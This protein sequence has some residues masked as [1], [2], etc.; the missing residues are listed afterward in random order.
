[1]KCFG[2]SALHFGCESN[3]CAKLEVGKENCV[4]TF[5]K[6][7]YCKNWETCSSDC[8]KKETITHLQPHCKIM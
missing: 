8:I 7:T 1:M 2:I 3:C 5:D 6:K 4:K